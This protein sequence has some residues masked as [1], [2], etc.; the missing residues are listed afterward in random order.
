MRDVAFRA[1]PPFRLSQPST[2]HAFRTEIHAFCQTALAFRFWLSSDGE[3]RWERTERKNALL[4]AL[5]LVN[6]SSSIWLPRVSLPDVARRVQFSERV[7]QG[8][9]VILRQRIAGRNQFAAG[10]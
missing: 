10:R 9:P 3:Q 6:R 8:L 7:R 5:R 2:F 4:F 1:F